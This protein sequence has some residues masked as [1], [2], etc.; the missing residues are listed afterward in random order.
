MAVI[1]ERTEARFYER[2]G[3]GYVCRLCPHGCVIP[4]GKY[5]RC[6]SRRADEDMLIAYT[7]GKVSS[8]CVDPIEKKPLYHY[9]PGSRCFSVGGVGCNM[10][11]RHCQ[12]YAISQ[13]SSGKKRTTYERPDE[14]VA[15]CRRERQNII[16][17]TY[18]EPSIWFEYI[19]DIMKAAPDLECLIISNGLICEEPLRQLCEVADAF[20]IDIKGFTDEFY[21][22][23]C[24]AH[25]RD[26][27]RSAKIVHGCGIHLELT[28]L[29]IPGYNDADD[30]IER[31]CRWVLDELSADV[32]VHFTRFHPDNEMTDVQWTPVETVLRCR[33]IG[34]K[35]GLKYV[36][37]GNTLSDEADD[38]YCPGCGMAV[39]RRL[40]YLVDRT[41][42]DGSRCSE[43]GYRLNIIPRSEKRAQLRYGVS[44]RDEDHE[45]NHGG[46]GDGA[47]PGLPQSGD[48]APVRFSGLY[49]YDPPVSD[50]LRHPYERTLRLVQGDPVLGEHPDPGVSGQEIAEKYS[51]H[52]QNRQKR[53]ADQRR[54][55]RGNEIPH[56]KISGN[57]RGF[58]KRMQ[59]R[60]RNHRLRV[61]APSQY[62]PAVHPQIQKKL[63]RKKQNRGALSRTPG[64]KESQRRKRDENR[65]G[66]R[67]G[68]PFRED[69][70]H[71]REGGCRAEENGDRGNELQRN[72]RRRRDPENGHQN[73]VGVRN[74]PVFQIVHRGRRQYSGREHRLESLQHAVMI[75]CFIFTDNMR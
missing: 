56:L 7:Y 8:L 5:G 54:D 34:M 35:C 75:Y 33:E 71:G 36:Y 2:T 37:V 63:R 69:E 64:G 41:G 61:R 51:E 66:N 6:G 29:V 55:R 40:G 16:A 39:V 42:L 46:H 26:V 68:N 48:C 58:R 21:V 12:N 24:G 43:C 50:V 70:R 47:G 30:E 74:L 4:V 38:T 49:A 28:Y 11:C 73:P 62:S 52:R 31:F 14:I 27:L 60:Y 18:N 25:L 22:Q 3:N 9:K 65:D 10:R 20:N 1:N 57:S 72:D 59:S 23:V 44:C 15:L 45:R 19:M 53:R 67:R 17:F 13:L 32:P